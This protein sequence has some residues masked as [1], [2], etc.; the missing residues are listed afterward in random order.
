[1]KKMNFFNRVV[2][3]VSALLVTSGLF[4]QT[5]FNAWEFKSGSN[6]I[7]S[8]HGLDF[9]SNSITVEYWI[10]MAPTGLV[11]NTNIME[12]F[13][14]PYGI[15]INVRENSE[16]GNAL[17]MRL[18]LK[19]ATSPTPQAISFFIPTEYYIEKWA[20]IA[21]VVSE[22]ENKA[23]VYVN[24]E[25]FG[26]ATATGGY[27]GNYR[28]SDNA[29]RTFNLGGLFWNN[30]N[31]ALIDTKLA[32][33]RVWSVARTAEEIK[34]N[35]NKH[36]TGTHEENPGLYLNYRFDAFIRPFNNDANPRTADSND[37]INRGWANPNVG[38]WKELHGLETLSAYPRNIA[39]SDQVLSWDTS[40][41]TWEVTIFDTDDQ[42]VHSETVA[43]NSISM[44]DIDALSDGTTYYA[45]VRTLNNGVYSG[46]VTS[47]NF[48]KATTGIGE[49]EIGATFYVNNGSLIVNAESAQTLNIYALSGQLVRSIDI[50]AGE[51]VINGL[52][53][54][55]YLAN[56]QK[57][58]IR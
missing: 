57:I 4:A 12:T 39:F 9:V 55:F 21:F 18:F 41:G 34:A 54:G 17:E 10:N 7:G 31:P 46:F 35:Y 40:D 42:E 5:D 37:E 33:V 6:G 19:D 23:F 52:P 49:T 16:K 48:T 26:E 27:Y 15:N 47:D 22:A 45:K 36:L 32:D 58:I 44:N 20:H 25:Q 1:M 53:K 14:D 2:L 28:K 43:T 3:I 50:V 38:N 8:A 56:N 13:G 29:R 11:K 30:N 24:G 51:N